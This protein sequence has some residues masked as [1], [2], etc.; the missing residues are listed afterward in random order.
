M[1]MIS[2]VVAVTAVLLIA[3]LVIPSPA[4][5]FTITGI[6][7]GPGRVCPDPACTCMPE[8]Q[9][10]SLGYVRCSANETPCFN[11]SAGRPLYCYHS[12]SSGTCSYAGC[13]G[14]GTV[15]GS[16]TESIHLVIT[17]QT[18]A[19]EN[20]SCS[21]TGS[22]ACSLPGSTPVSAAADPFAGI[23]AFFRSLFGMR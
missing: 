23:L 8:G 22:D 14:N 7:A 19:A 18:P 6:S 2:A 11:D 9:A 1:R 3:S 12:P 13:T 5:A 20:G 4:C 17:M 21:G 10:A 15:S 16:G